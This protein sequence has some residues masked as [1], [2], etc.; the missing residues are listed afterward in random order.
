MTH[1][2]N[3]LCNDCIIPLPECICTSFQYI[4]YPFAVH[5]N[6]GLHHIFLVCFMTIILYPSNA[7]LRWD[8]TMFSIKHFLQENVNKIIKF[9]IIIFIFYLVIRVLKWPNNTPYVAMLIPTYM[10]K[11]LCRF[12]PIYCTISRTPFHQ[13]ANRRL[14]NWQ[15]SHC[16]T[17]WYRPIMASIGKQM[18]LRLAAAAAPHIDNAG[19][20]SSAEPL[21]MTP[22]CTTHTWMTLFVI[23]KRSETAHKLSEENTLH[24]PLKFTI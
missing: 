1:L 23:K 19:R 18:D 13:S 17:W 10:W 14:L 12:L 7:S 22:K 4:I 6:I 16:L 15:K 5:L 20:A 3:R 2:Y 11:K 8:Y 21:R 9:T 24:P